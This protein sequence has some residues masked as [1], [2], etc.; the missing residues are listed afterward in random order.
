MLLSG[1]SVSFQRLFIGNVTPDLSAPSALQP[2]HWRATADLISGL[3]AHTS[4]CSPASIPGSGGGWGHHPAAMPA[5]TSV[6]GAR[7]AGIQPCA[8]APCAG[9]AASNS[10]EQSGSFLFQ[11]L[12]ITCQPPPALSN[13]R[14]NIS[15]PTLPQINS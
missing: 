9:I 7:A 4:A 8:G 6:C 11:L 15:S 10:W 2:L 1:G 3:D 12:P 14:D 5:Q 13:Q